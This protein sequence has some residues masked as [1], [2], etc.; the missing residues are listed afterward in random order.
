MKINNGNIHAL[1]VNNYKAKENTKIEGKNRSKEVS[2]DT[3]ELSVLGKSLN[4]LALEE[5]SV[6]MSNKEVENIKSKVSNG[7]YNIDSQVLAKAM[8]EFMKGGQ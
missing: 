3:C 4:K 5:E 8:M 1:Y 6:G 7:T 2:K